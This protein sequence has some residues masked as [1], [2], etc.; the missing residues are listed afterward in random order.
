MQISQATVAK[1]TFSGGARV[2]QFADGRPPIESLGMNKADMEIALSR[3][4]HIVPESRP[5]AIVPSRF[6]RPK[7]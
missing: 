2:L 7:L 4:S 6:Q 3:L 5:E 1:G